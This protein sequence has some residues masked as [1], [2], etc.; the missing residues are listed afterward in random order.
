MPADYGLPGAEIA[1][2][3]RRATAQPRRGAGVPAGQPAG[4]GALACAPRPDTRVVAAVRRLALPAADAAALA[5]A[6]AVTGAAGRAGAGLVCACYGLAVLGIL[7]A[8][9]Q[10]RLRICLRSSD[11]A[12][13][14]LIATTVPLPALLGWWPAGQLAWL[15]VCSAGFMFVGRSAL[16]AALRAAHRRDRLTEPALIVGS[17]TFGAYVADL[18]RA[19]PELGLRPRG[20]LD[21]GPPRRDLSL[22]SLGTPADLAGVVAK[23]GIRRV[24]VCFSTC[25]DEDFVAVIRASLPLRADVCVVPRLYELGAAVP[26]GCLDEIWGIP[27]VPLRSSGRS[28]ADRALKRAADLAA[29]LVLLAAAAPVLLAMAAVT[30]LRSGQPAFFGQARITGQGRIVRVLKLRTLAGT[31]DP[32]TRWTVPAGQYGPLGRWMRA[33]HIDE[34]PQLLNVVR[35]Q[36]SLVGPRPERP[37][38]AERFSREIPRYAD[39]TR[40]LAG[41]TGWAQ[42]HGLNGDTSIFER[43]RFD[44]YYAEYWSPWLDAVILARTLAVMA[45]GPRGGQP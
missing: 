30:R 21:D 27:L 20:F 12:D 6:V 41:M 15:A 36:M 35:G 43:A 40:M 24:I 7:A 37:F 18:L 14:I 3:R 8:S 33:T 17:G 45:P 11:Q 32:D 31:D 4:T 42:V 39:R 26:R 13:R 5:V 2:A 16:Y 28:L 29:A 34:L 25:R 19:H 23:L 1:A 44:N 38:F 10:Y 9:R 22:P